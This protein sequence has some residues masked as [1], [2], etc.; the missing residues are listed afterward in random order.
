MML[1]LRYRQ[2]QRHFGGNPLWMLSSPRTIT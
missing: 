1:R 2:L